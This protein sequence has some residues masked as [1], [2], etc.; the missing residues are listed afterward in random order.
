M[1]LPCDVR[2]EIGFMNGTSVGHVI[3]IIGM[4][5]CIHAALKSTGGIATWLAIRVECYWQV[6]TMHSQKKAG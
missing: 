2:K 3:N 5:Q 4:L 1:F 6:I